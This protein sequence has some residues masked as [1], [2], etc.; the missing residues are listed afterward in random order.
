[1]KQ[2]L[3]IVIPA[4]DEESAI[5]DTI[6]RCLAARDHIAAAADLEDVEVIVVS[7]GSTDRTEAIARSFPEVTVLAFERNRGYGAAI[8][9]GFAYGRGELV[10]FLDADGTCDP[11]VFAELVVALNEHSAEVALGSRLGEGSEMPRVR[12]LGNLL[13]AA[14][15][16]VLSRRAVRDTASGM[17]VIRRAALAQLYPLPDGLHFTPAMSARILLEGKLTLVEVPMPYAERVG[18]S[19]LSV[20]RDGVRFL[21]SI[22]QAAIAYR[23]ARL[24]LLGAGAAA[25]ISFATGI[26]PLLHWLSHTEVEEWMIYRVLVSSL[27]GSVTALLICAAVLGDRIAAL[28]HERALVRSGVTALLGRMLMP[29]ARWLVAGA[30]TF[31]GVVVTWPGIVEYLTT[32]TVSMHWSRGVLG[33]L[34]LMLTAVVLVTGFL[35]DMLALIQTQ[36]SPLDP[37]T[38]PDRVRRGQPGA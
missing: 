20:V 37:V 38:P 33:S 21:R 31:A 1:M 4:L 11:L 9:C 28:A 35:L 15:L 36:R 7:D 8:K 29:P 17:R 19:K 2:T 14:M 24:L 18:E 26:G 22:V 34:L 30:L 13:F 32:S 3:S 12:A 6:E 23:P 27:F 25:A 5:G 10:G 16:G